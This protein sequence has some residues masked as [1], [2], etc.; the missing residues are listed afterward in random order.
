M[1]MVNSASEARKERGTVLRPGI[2]ASSHRGGGGSEKSSTF[3][4]DEDTLN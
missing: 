1:Q 3:R 2:D 4:F